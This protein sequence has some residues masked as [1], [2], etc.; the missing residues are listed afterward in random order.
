M[1]AIAKRGEGGLLLPL[2]RLFRRTVDGRKE[3]EKEHAPRPSCLV[4]RG[5]GARIKKGSRALPSNPRIGGGASKEGRKGEEKA[6]SCHRPR[7]VHHRLQGK[8]NAKLGG[9]RKKG[10]KREGVRRRLLITTCWE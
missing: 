2:S 5:D 7:R 6:A 1:A 10:R 8:K 4:I 3:E 9:T